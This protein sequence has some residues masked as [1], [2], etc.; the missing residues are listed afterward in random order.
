MNPEA[1]SFSTF[2]AQHED[3]QLHHD[4]TDSIQEIVAKLNNAVMEKGGVHSAKLN[5]S[6]EFKIDSGAIE[7]KATHTVALP[8]LKRPKTIYWCTPDN[9]LTRKNPKQSE[10][11]FR[12]V[13][14]SNE[15]RDAM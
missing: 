3:G 8:K 13:K 12:D 6:L 10:L 14:A 4:L 11:P 1:L 2:V 5:L 15:I 7:I 9:C